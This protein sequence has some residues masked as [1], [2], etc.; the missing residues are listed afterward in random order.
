MDKFWLTAA[1]QWGLVKL[2]F[3]FPISILIN[4]KWFS[5]YLFISLKKKKMIEMIILQ[6]LNQFDLERVCAA[7]CSS[8]VWNFTGPPVAVYAINMQVM[9][10]ELVKCYITW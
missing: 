6:L 7:R 3:F 4:P 1:Q 9:M 2:D 10:T 5:P 8:L